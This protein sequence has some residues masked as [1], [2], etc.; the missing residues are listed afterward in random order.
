MTK[1]IAITLAF[2]TVACSNNDP[3]NAEIEVTDPIL[4]A[5]ALEAAQYWMR[6]TDG[7]VFWSIIDKCEHNQ[8]CIT[9]KSGDLTWITTPADEMGHG[10]SE[11]PYGRT[12]NHTA[13]FTLERNSFITID[14]LQ[15]PK[16]QLYIMSI[17]THELGHVLLRGVWHASKYG[18]SGDYGSE[19]MEPMGDLP[20]HGCI[21][22]KSL[23]RY[24]SLY[25][26]GDYQEECW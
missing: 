23:A 16:N 19:V 4:K 6:A 22:Q 8:Y 11:H 25:G 20:G 21:G 18:I 17:V 3:R 14:L 10:F 5:A 15:V 2:I 24:E 13:D 7:D 26:K 9:L 12:R 1:L